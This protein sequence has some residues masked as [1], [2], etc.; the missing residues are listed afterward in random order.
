MTDADADQQDE[1]GAADAGADLPA[2][3]RAALDKL[4]AGEKIS[5]DEEKLLAAHEDK[6]GIEEG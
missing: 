2:D 4:M 1:K 6:L 3:V 5:A